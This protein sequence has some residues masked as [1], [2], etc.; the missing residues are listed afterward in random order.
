MFPNMLRI[1]NKDQGGLP[2]WFSNEQSNEKRNNDA[3][4]ADGDQSCVPRCIGSGE[5]NRN[6]AGDGLT[7]I[8]PNVE[9][10]RPE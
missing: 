7:N 3:Y 4:N 9:N 10:T 6:L 1:R 2:S 8:N 5:R